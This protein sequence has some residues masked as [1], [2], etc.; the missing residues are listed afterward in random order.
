M[1]PE[2]ALYWARRFAKKDDLPP[3]WTLQAL[4]WLLSRVEEH[5]G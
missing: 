3:L 2:V 4:R 5:R 1:T